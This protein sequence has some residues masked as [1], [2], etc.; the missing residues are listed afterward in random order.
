MNIKSRLQRWLKLRFAIVYPLAIAMI[1]FAYPTPASIKRG[2]GFI[3][4]GLLLRLWANCY[5]IKMEKLTT[6]GPYAYVRHPLYLGTMLLSIGIILY[7]NLKWWGLLFF[8]VIAVVYGRTV[9]IEEKMLEDKF[10]ERYRAYKNKVPAFL[11]T[12]FAYRQGEKWKASFATLLRS[13]EYKL[14]FWTIILLIYFYLKARLLVQKEP[15]TAADIALIAAATA[16]MSLD[17]LGEIF[18]IRRRFK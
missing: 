4:A 6:C 7:L 15:L 18:H 5:A 8:A 1:I 10:K 14:L 12:V 16:L 9:K 2:I 11:P 17:I 3:I 13:Q